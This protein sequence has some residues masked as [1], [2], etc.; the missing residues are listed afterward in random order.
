M[1]VSGQAKKLLV[2]VIGGCALFPAVSRCAGEATVIG[3]VSEGWQ[4]AV[5]AWAAT[6]VDEKE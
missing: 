6:I 3:E 5:G 4:T 1:G 2:S